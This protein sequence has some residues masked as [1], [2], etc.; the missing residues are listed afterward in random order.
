MINPY[1]KIDK[2]KE[3][4]N[5]CNCI[6]VNIGRVGP[7][8]PRGERGEKGDRGPAGQDGIADTITVGVTTTGEAGTEASVTD[9]KLGNNHILDFVI[10]KGP[11][12]PEGTLVNRSAYLVTFNASTTPGGIPVLSN[13]NIPID[14][15]ELD[16]SKII[17]LDTNRYL[18]KFNVEGYYKISFTINAYPEVHGQDFDPTKDIVSV[19]FRETNTDNVYV[20]VGEFV[21]NGESVELSASGI[22]SVV[23][24]A[25]TY[26]LANLGKYTIYLET[27]DLNNI[28]S[29]SYFANPLVTIVIEFLGRPGV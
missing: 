4:L 7:T 5:K 3:C 12:G 21:Y 10:P 11:P 23:D 2:D 9:T 22:I 14:R 20:G 27:P 6:P 28:L 17:E 25:V 8:G 18:I 24:T 29:N 13:Q 16:I 26:E 15:E 19:G 1:N